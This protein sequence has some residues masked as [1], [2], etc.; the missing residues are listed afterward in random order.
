MKRVLLVAVVALGALGMSTAG[1]RRAN[2]QADA[3][4]MLQSPD[5]GERRDAADDLMDGQPTPQTV[6]ALIAALE[7][8]QDAKTYAMILLALGKSGAPEAKPYIEANLGNKNKVVRDRAEKALQMWSA[9][10]PNG[11]QPGAGV[12]PLPGEQPGAP[13]PPPGVAPEPPGPP[14]PPP[15]PPAPTTPG[16]GQEI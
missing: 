13:P 6:Q 7:K 5:P 14:P 1:C 3:M 2:S 16:Q 11:V 15:P 8:E 4:M 9:R 12:P 10:N